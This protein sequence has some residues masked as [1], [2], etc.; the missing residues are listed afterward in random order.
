MMTY[1]EEAKALVSGLDDRMGPSPYDIAWMARVRHPNNNEPRWPDLLDWLIHNQH[2]D[3]SWGGSITYYHDRIICTLAAAIALQENRDLSAAVEESIERAERYLWHH[4]HLLPRDPFELVGF[5]LIF[6][7]L[8]EEARKLSLNVPAHACGYGKIQTE[9]LRLIPPDMLYSPQITT[10]HSLEFLGESGDPD[11]M[12]KALACNGSLGN[13]PS[14]TAY[15]LTFRPDD[16]RAVDYLESIRSHM[17]H[18]IYLYPFS[19]FELAWVLNNLTSSG[20]PIR[21]FAS[22]SVWEQITSEMGPQGVGLDAT[23]GIPDADTTAVSLYLMA[24][25]GYSIDPHI[26]FQF[27]DP[28]NHIFRT[29]HY[30]RN[31]SVSTNIHALEAL[32][33]MPDYPNQQRIKE[34]V[35]A[36]LLD[37]RNY[38]V[39][40][41]DKWHASPYYV[42]AHT[43]LAL[44]NAGEYLAKACQHTIDWI[45]NTQLEDGSWGFFQ[46]GTLEE[47]AY[48]LIALLQYYQHQI[49]IDADVLHRGV[50]YLSKTHEISDDSPDLWLGKDLYNPRDVVDSAILSALILYE[51]VFGCV[52]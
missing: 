7:T 17:G 18:V 20:T 29:Y 3:G 28:E 10:V 23:F 41:T 33:F 19:N 40:W 34:Q 37:C 1:T 26:L 16:T 43:L 12:A 46:V 4:I 8:L 25:A 35:I 47:T 6:P 5:E 22:E 49:P 32:R 42:T 51:N 15:Y 30:E 50:A 36:M 14:A 52:P 44:L 21:E 27:E 31:P 48:A 9:K 13:S 38:N 2:S 24:Q 45:V 39:Y 11:K